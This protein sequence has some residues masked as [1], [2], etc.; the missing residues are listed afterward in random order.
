M[1]GWD[2]MRWGWKGLEIS[3]GRRHIPDI[4]WRE[5]RRAG[6]YL[7]RFRRHDVVYCANARQMKW[8]VKV[9]LRGGGGGGEGKRK[10]R[11][12][13]VMAIGKMNAP[14]Y[15][16]LY[17]R[18]ENIIA[19]PLCELGCVLGYVPNQ[20]Q[21]T[22]DDRTANDRHRLLTSDSSEYPSEFL[23]FSIIFCRFEIFS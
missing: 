9:R 10:T 2:E 23:H 7:H 19:G 20:V 17:V 8:R 14:W 12:F 6:W 18:R 4:I 15:R 22:Y 16:R 5:W 1:Q 21:T 3:R 11:P 13:T